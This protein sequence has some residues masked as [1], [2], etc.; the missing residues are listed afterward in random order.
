MTPEE[1]YQELLRRQ[2][3]LSINGDMLSFTAPESGLTPE[4][5]GAMKRHKRWLLER[6]RQD[7]SEQAVDD[8]I[9]AASHGQ[10][11]LWLLHRENPQ[12]ASYNTAAALRILSPINV[13]GLERSVLKLMLRH[14]ALRMTFRTVAGHLQAV[15][16]KTPRVD[17]QQI[18]AATWD[19]T[20]LREAVQLEYA[21]PFDL[22]DGPLLRVRLFSQADDR[23]VLL[24]TLH[25]IVFDAA[26]LWI[27]QTEMQQLYRSEV[28]GEAC[29][30][31]VLP[32]SYGDLTAS[33]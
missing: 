3:K 7:S 32:A 4:L 23:H 25:H 5:I 15:V 6:V 10:E 17:F 27:L 18:D 22:T 30:Q 31:P 8:T 9:Y 2:V 26:S 1:L 33:R 13:A 24:M 21:R 12:S 20:Q 16:G 29:L 19:E 28:S 11:A 14:D